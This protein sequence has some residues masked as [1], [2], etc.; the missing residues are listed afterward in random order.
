MINKI[1]VNHF[2]AAFVEQIIS[3]NVQNAG[4]SMVTKE[5]SYADGKKFIKINI[6]FSFI[7]VLNSHKKL[8]NQFFFFL[9]YF[10]SSSKVQ[11][12]SITNG[13]RRYRS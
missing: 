3:D 7:L 4:N 10:I 8:K 2:S 1:F 12:T 9:I 5:L 6:I 13:M 11:S